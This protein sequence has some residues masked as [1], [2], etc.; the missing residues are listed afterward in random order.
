MKC[1]KFEDFESGRMTKEEFALHAKT[2]PACGGEAALQDRLDREIGSLRRPLAAPGL[3]ERI[4]KRL[5]EEKQA[6][7]AGTPA[8][9]SARTRLRRR[10][11]LILVPAAAV[12]LAA[13]LIP[14]LVSKRTTPASGLLA[15]SALARVEEKENEYVR[16]IEELEKQA[17]PR[18]GSLD[19]SLMSLYRD[20][21][22]VIDSQI[23]TCREALRSNPA[24]AHLRRY[25]FAALKD[26]K[27][28][29]AEILSHKEV[30]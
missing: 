30:S 19:F 12:L 8:I 15:G 20:K 29:L 25:L 26:K 22:A 5:L 28:T 4:E 2:C 3:W 21:L 23:E 1:R 24:N 10:I 27:D 14:L 6:A 17:R 7:L 9:R 16:A 13:V 18:I 11:S